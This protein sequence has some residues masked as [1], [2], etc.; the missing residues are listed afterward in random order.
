MHGKNEVY[1]IF[2]HSI[3][4]I[5]HKFKVY[6]TRG[7]F[8]QVPRTRIRLSFVKCAY[9]DLRDF[10]FHNFRGLKWIPLS[11]KGW[12]PTSKQQLWHIVSLGFHFLIIKQ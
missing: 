6:L 1:N 12:H 4:F 9:S 3:T 7:T 11:Q 10:F 5:T 2:H 8:R